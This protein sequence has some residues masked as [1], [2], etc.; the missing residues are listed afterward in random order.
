M[1]YFVGDLHFGHSNILEYEKETRGKYWNSV[2]EMNEGLIKL[3]N[4]TITKDDIVYNIGDFFFNM[5]PKDVK[6]ILKQLNY[7]KMIL[8]AGNHDHRKMIKLFEQEG[9][10]VKYADMIR[11][12]GVRYYLSHYPTLI[13]RKNL[14]NIHGHIHS[15][16]METGYHINVDYDFTGKIAISFDELIEFK[17]KVL[18]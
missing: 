12:D 15:D 1:I 8:I 11:R 18:K 10:T 2:E 9:I 16:F 7:K 14:Y 13:G 6:R 3:W 5:K 17:N 4:E